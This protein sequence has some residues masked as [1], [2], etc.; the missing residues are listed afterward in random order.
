M[1]LLFV[2]GAMNLLW[3]AALTGLVFVRK[4]CPERRIGSRG[5]A[6][7]ASMIGAGVAKW[8]WTSTAHED[9]CV[10]RQQKVCWHAKTHF[11]LVRDGALR[12]PV[13]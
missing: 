11:A 5:G 3:I 4:T 2:G 12:G 8:A 9:G 13:V 1:A 7:A 10:P 6:S